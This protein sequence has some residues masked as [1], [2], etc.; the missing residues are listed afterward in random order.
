MTVTL[1]LRL[2]GGLNDRSH[3]RVRHRKWKAEKDAVGFV[4][5]TKGELP[6][7]L[8]CT[9]TITRIAPSNGLDDDNLAGACKAVRD[10][11]A[12]W[13]GIDDRRSDVVAYRY[14]QERGPWGVRI[15]VSR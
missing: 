11:V 8:P 5:N 4:L 1:P 10:A 2:G 7:V 9:V 15:E 3:W 6:L 12:T 13:I 14:A